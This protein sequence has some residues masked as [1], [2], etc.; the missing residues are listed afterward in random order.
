ML[1]EFI[2]IALCCSCSSSVLQPKNDKLISSVQQDTNMMISAM[3]I[4]EDGDDVY[5]ADNYKTLMVLKDGQYNILDECL[6]QE[7][8][9]D[10]Y[11]DD[12]YIFYIKY[13]IDKSNVMRI[14]KDNFRDK[15]SLYEV[16]HSAT[17]KFGSD[18][19]YADR[20]DIYYLNASTYTLYK[21]NDK[22]G[23]KR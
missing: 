9:T 11:A 8:I 20:S 13:D 21:F 4:F 22:Y 14:S 19:I 1:M 10:I 3:P 18:Y 2:I 15:T 5:F 17:V 7:Q 6:P 12:E 23:F 16:S